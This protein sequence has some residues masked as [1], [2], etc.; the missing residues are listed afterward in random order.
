MSLVGK[1]VGYNRQVAR[2][3]EKHVPSLFGNPSYQDE[4]L[5]RIYNDLEA[6]KAPVVLE[7]GGIDRPLLRR[8]GG[9]EYVGVDIE[10]RPDCSKVYDKFIVQSIV[11]P[12]DLDNADLVISITLMEH[13][14]DNRAAVKSMFRALRGGG[15]SHHYIPG[16]WHPYAIATRIVGPEMQRRLIKIIRPE[17][18][19]VTGYPAFFD[20][21]TPDEMARLFREAGF[22][23]VSVVPYYRASDYF[24]FFLPAYLALVSFENLCRDRDLRFFASGFVISARKPGAPVRE[25]DR[26]S[27][28]A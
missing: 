2:A 23:D 24:S 28:S 18:V 21:C 1:L 11:Q 17:A 14:P 9:F 5:S 20:H 12:L 8:D 22:E 13:V 3:L 27:A 26:P 4:L 15:T 19:A 6:S 16:K 10:A 25:A 7:I